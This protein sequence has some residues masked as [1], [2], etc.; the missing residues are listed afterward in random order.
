MWIYNPWIKT[1]NT[2]IHISKT[3]KFLFTL[4]SYSNHRIYR[5]QLILI[6]FPILYITWTAGK[7]LVLQDTLCR[8]IP[9]EIM[10]SKT[11]SRNLTKYKVFM[12]KKNRMQKHTIN[13]PWKCT[14]KKLT[15]FPIIFR[16]PKQPLWSKVIRKFYFKANTIFIID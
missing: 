8:N 13:W 2:L 10:K 6:K 11:D 15:T 1:S 16:L 4:K 7:N 9:P 12:Q 14:N 3:K 5:L